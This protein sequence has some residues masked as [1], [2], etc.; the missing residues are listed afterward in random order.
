M[1]KSLITWSESN[2]TAAKARLTNPLLAPAYKSLIAAADQALDCSPFS[3]T[4]KTTL[5]PSGDKHDY[6]SI[7]PYW[8]PD[9]SKLDG[10]P[11]INR[12]G[13]FNPASRDS[14]TDSIRFKEFTSVLES[15]SL[16]YYFSDDRKYADKA[17]ALLNAWFLDAET[18]MHPHLEYGQGIAGVT[19]GRGIGLIDTRNITTIIDS[20]IILDPVLTEKQVRGLEDWFEQFLQWL[21]T[22]KNGLE[23][24]NQMNNHGTFYDSQVA[25]IAIFLGKDD[26]A[27]DR[28][29]DTLT[30]R[31]PEQIESDGRQPK[32]LHR[33][34]SF[35]YSAFNLTAYA[36]VARYGQ[37]LGLDLWHADPSGTGSPML[38]TAI[39]WLASFIPNP[40][41][42]PYPELTGVQ[43]LPLAMDGALPVF[44]QALLEFGTDQDLSTALGI[45][46]KEVPEARDWLIWPMTEADLT[47]LA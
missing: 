30:N 4:H 9:A 3:V 40:N 29:R 45:A 46:A 15:L 32:E 18:L 20:I 26:L 16:A 31:L 41:S 28:I 23:E 5:P 22:S 19:T 13:E 7:A 33:T 25:C 27:K 10:L 11:Y 37:L 44:L 12:D 39:T 38:K 1:K 21:C 6:L 34:R 2:L 35:H 42:W 36:R 8:W 47:A 17:V 14:S 43:V 24:R